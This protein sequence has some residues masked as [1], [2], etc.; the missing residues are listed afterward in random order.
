MADLVIVGELGHGSDGPWERRHQLVRDEH[1]NP[2]AVGGWLNRTYAV[3]W[4]Q[5]LTKPGIDHLC[6]KRHDNGTDISWPDL[7]RIK[8]RLAPNGQLR[9]AIEVFPPRLAVVDNCNL[10]HLW[11]MPLGWV[12][13]VDF[14]EPGVRV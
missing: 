13:P 10:R 6:V 2:A 14:N 3:T 4:F 12:A 5:H 11:V 1:P 8:D 9:W 7:Q